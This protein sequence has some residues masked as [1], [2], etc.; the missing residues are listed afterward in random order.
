MELYG[1]LKDNLG[2]ALSSVKRLRGHPVHADT[3]QHWSELLHHS[4]RQLAEED[5]PDREP[6]ERLALE[7]QQALA[8][9]G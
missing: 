1:S 2:A 4:R 5:R 8:E 3:L 7:L 9:R 6:I